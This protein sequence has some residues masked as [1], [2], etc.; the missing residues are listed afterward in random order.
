LYGT[1][2]EFEQRLPAIAIGAANS[3]GFPIQWMIYKNLLRGSDLIWCI[4]LPNQAIASG[5]SHSNIKSP[6]QAIASGASH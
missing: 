3:T 6:N 1:T 5:A 4:K 2:A